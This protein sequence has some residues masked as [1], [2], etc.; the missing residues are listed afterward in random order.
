MGRR[1]GIEGFTQAEKLC[2]AALQLDPS[3]S[4]AWL[5]KANT[6]QARLFSEDPFAATVSTRLN[7]NRV[8]ELEELT[9]HAVALDEND[10]TAWNARADAL[11][12]QHRW[13][14]A[15]EARSRSL[16]LDPSRSSTYGHQAWDQIY[17]GRPG[18]ALVALEKEKEVDPDAARGDDYQ[19][20]V[21]RA[22]LVL[23]HYDEAIRNCENA[24]GGGGGEDA[25]TQIFLAAAYA[26]KGD[27]AKAWAARDRAQTLLPGMTITSWKTICAEF[28]DATA[29]WDQQ[30][31]YIVPGMRK[32]G[33]RE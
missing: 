16:Q 7:P 28:S 11:R 5:C 9:R 21:C 2:D 13:E 4:A 22:Q 14:A 18:E 27:S 32:A 24:A 20:A 23:G 25:G 12:W 19:S 6:V 8:A 26:L 1:D 33:F 29:Y 31:Q 3:L 15:A 17:A 30:E 10:S